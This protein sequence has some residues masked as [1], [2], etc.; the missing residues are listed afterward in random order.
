MNLIHLHHRFH[1]FYLPLLICIFSIGL[2]FTTP[3]CTDPASPPAQNGNA[4][5]GSQNSESSEDDPDC[6]SYIDNA[7]SMLEPDRLG[8]SSSLERA[9]GLLNQ[10]TFK[11]GEFD[12]KPPTLTDSQK[13]YFQK[14]LSEAQLAK[15]D[16]TRFTKEDGKYIRDARLFYGMMNAAI[17]D[18]SNDVD[19][20]TAIFYYCM[21]NIAIVTN[22]ANELPLSPYEV[23]I[24]GM[25]T[26]EQRAWVYI[27]MLR[28]LHIDAVLFRPSEPAPY[29]LLVGVL[30]DQKIYLFDPTLGLPVPAVE[31]PADAIL[32]QN[33]ADLKSVYQNSDILKNF[34][35]DDAANR[36]STEELKSAQVL[37]VGRSSEWSARMRRL[38]DSLSRKLTF[39]LFRNLEDFEGEP[40][41]ITHIQTIGDGI[42]KQA[43]IKVSEY[44]DEE[45]T[46]SQSAT[47]DT[48]KRIALL[49]M[50]FR[51]PVPYTV[52]RKP[53]G[54]EIKWGPPARKLLKTRT[55]QLMGNQQNA[56]QSYLTIRLEKDF[57]AGMAVPQ[58]TRYMHL[59]AAEQA[60]YFLALGQY[61]QGEDSSATKSF[62]IYLNRYGRRDRKLVYHGRSLAAMYLQAISDAKLGK[63]RSAVLDFTEKKTPES[64]KPAFQ[65]LAKRWTVL[66]DKKSN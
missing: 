13:P 23:C 53:E 34:Y 39:V 58:E 7:M 47:E 49:K 35:G 30:I 40:G 42:L 32:V 17:K 37:I 19:R 66:R 12:S 41:F 52:N 22:E 26:A 11:C 27:N 1:R 59:M 65:Y 55:I 31:Q 15:M 8:I 36:F 46:K 29:K 44:P 33:P 60:T 63:F 5:N 20:A 50:P 43:S 10:W 54:I 24:L 56:I 21:N 51:A 2:L 3:S 45:M 14:Y 28:Q 61:L 9:I 57:P 62:T 64:V 48:A 4:E 25:G 6:N 16:L 38:E 18:Q